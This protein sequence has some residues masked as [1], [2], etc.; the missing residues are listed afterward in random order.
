MPRACKTEIDA[1][2]VIEFVR[3]GNK[4][5]DQGVWATRLEK[6][7][8]NNVLKLHTGANEMHDQGVV[9]L[10]VP[11]CDIKHATEIGTDIKTC[12]IIPRHEAFFAGPMTGILMGDHV[13]PK[14]HK[15][16]SSWHITITRA[17]AI[18]DEHDILEKNKCQTLYSK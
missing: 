9:R 16:G 4:I 13:S 3:N 8:T 2:K 12:E 17:K 18:A 7:D 11:P 5:S 1:K 10:S 6:V 14:L 15:L